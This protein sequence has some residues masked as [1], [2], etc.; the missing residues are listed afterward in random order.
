LIFIHFDCLQYFET[1]SIETCQLLTIH[2]NDE[3]IFLVFAHDEL[4]L[5]HFTRK[6]IHMFKYCR[7][8]WN[9]TKYQNLVV[10]FMICFDKKF[11]V[12]LQ[13]VLLSFLNSYRVK[14]P[15]KKKKEKLIDYFLRRNYFNISTK[16]MPSMFKSHFLFLTKN[17]KKF[18]NFDFFKNKHI[19]LIFA[20]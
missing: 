18:L 5:K 3:S 1:Q 17:L 6:L 19:I 2:G 10:F 20:F 15:W 12:L 7:V 11:E 4:L 16:Q 14:F 8:I 9:I 13:S